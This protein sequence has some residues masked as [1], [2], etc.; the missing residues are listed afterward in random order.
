[1]GLRFRKSISL[2]KGVRLNFSKKGVSLSS[3]IPG[4]RKTIHSNGRVTTS[5]GIPG[6]GI[7]YV[8]T[9][10]PSK[11]KDEKKSRGI[12][13]ELFGE[14][15]NSATTIY[16]NISAN[17]SSSYEDNSYIPA[18][19]TRS[20]HEVPTAK[21]SFT[22]VPVSVDPHKIKADIKESEGI[23][24]QTPVI[25]VPNTTQLAETLEVETDPAVVIEEKNS[26]E[27]TYEI[28]NRIFE[29]C[30]AAVDWIDVISHKLPTSDE[31]NDETWAYLHKKAVKVFEG[32]IDTYLEIIRTVNPYDDLLDYAENFEFGTDDPSVMEIEFSIIDTNTATLTK[33]VFEDYYSAI[34][35]RAARDTFALLPVEKTIVHVVH[36]GKEIVNASF[37]REKIHELDVVNLDASDLVKQ[38]AVLF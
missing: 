38:V 29:N 10:N 2:C 9:K 22:P 25:N 15:K 11:N 13:S 21:S 33:N 35:I 28:I 18:S 16:N 31:I 37:C 6:T 32:D 23:V 12:L 1:M 7:Y 14:N 4:F 8:D 34:T 19:H 3:G 30:D 27:I 20:T 5:I 26:K 17:N 36:K 24:G